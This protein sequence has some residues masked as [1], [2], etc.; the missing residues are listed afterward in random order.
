M[1]RKIKKNIIVSGGLF[2]GF[3]FVLIL[4][5]FFVNQ[6]SLI[7][8]TDLSNL[9]EMKSS[10]QSFP[11]RIA[12]A[13]DGDP[14]SFVI[15]RNNREDFKKRL[16]TLKEDHQTTMI[17][18][19]WETI[20]SDT[21]EILNAQSSIFFGKRVLMNLSGNLSSIQ[22]QYSELFDQFKYY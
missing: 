8:Q 15:L 1:T 12:S 16:E 13:L 3:I 14:G 19:L 4:N 6:K 20:V 21:G 2:V 7:L 9:S 17:D 11:K 10:I 18:T 22:E 5:A